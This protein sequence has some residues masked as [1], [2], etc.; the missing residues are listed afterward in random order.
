MW[1]NRSQFFFGQSCWS[2]GL[3]S[4]HYKELYAAV[5]SLRIF[6]YRLFS[7]PGVCAF[8]KSF[9][10]SQ[11][12]GKW[13]I[14]MNT[15]LAHRISILRCLTKFVEWGLLAETY[16]IK[17]FPPSFPPSL[18]LKPYPNVSSVP[19]HIIIVDILFLSDY[20]LSWVRELLVT[21]QELH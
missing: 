10:L 2:D 9:D 8:D 19:V 14:C 12:G 11:A 6:L 17:E 7:N 20:T 16:L 21:F 5:F 18:P 1:N 4:C 15:F 13:S 3:V